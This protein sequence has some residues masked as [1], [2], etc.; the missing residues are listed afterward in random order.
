MIGQGRPHRQGEPPGG[1]LVTLLFAVLAWAAPT[2][3][4]RAAEIDDA[5]NDALPEMRLRIVF[6]GG[7]PRLWRGSISL[8]DGQFLQP[9]LLGLEP[10]E[11]GSMSA[12]VRVIHVHQP[13]SRSYEGLDVLV[14]AP[15]EA[16]LSVRLAAA[17]DPVGQ[18]DFHL[19]LADLVSGIHPADDE[20]AGRLDALGNRLV[21]SRSPGDKLRVA[22]E[23]DGL[24]F[25]PGETF[26]F[27]VVPNLPGLEADTQLRMKLRIVSRLD[28]EEHFARQQEVKVAADGC[29]DAWGP[30]EFVLPAGDDVYELIV[31][32]SRP[33]LLDPLTE[34][35]PL[36]TTK[37]LLVRRLQLVAV[38]EEAPQQTDE[39][40]EQPVDEFDP[41][42]PNWSQRVARLP[43]L[44]R[45]PRMKQGRL[46]HG[47]VEVLEHQGRRWVQLAPSAWQAHPLSIAQPGTPHVLEVEYPNDVPQTL[48]ISVLQPNAVGT[49]AP[50]GVDSAVQVQPLA[51][52]RSPGTQR[53]RLIF[54]PRTKTPLLLLT[55]H[56]PQRPAVY[57][58]VRL[59]RYDGPLAPRM[60]RPAAG[61]R[62]I[63]AWFDKPLLPEMFSA[64]EA[65]D[66]STTRSLDD[67]RTF[68]EGSTRLVRYLQHVGY[69]TAVVPA[70]C[71]GSTLYPSDILQPTPKYDTGTFLTH[72]EDPQRKDVLELL[73]RLFDRQGLTLLPSL[74]FDTPLPELE[75]L[76]RENPHGGTG[77]QLVDHRG[78]TWL[79]RFSSRGGLAPYYNPLDERVQQAMTKV[80]AELVTRYGHH[81]SFGGVVLQLSPRGH[82]MLP[83]GGWGFDDRTFARFV[84]EAKVDD[85]QLERLGGGRNRFAQ[86]ARWCAGEGRSA[87]LAWRARRMAGLYG[88]MADEVRRV[89]PEGKLILAG[90]GMLDS[91]AL[92][93]ALRPTL[94]VKGATDQIVREAILE[95]GIDPQALAQIPAVKLIAPYPA[96]A[97]PQ[98]GQGDWDEG[99]VRQLHAQLA[100]D[101]CLMF[102]E[103]LT[104]HVP[105]FDAISPFGREKTYTWLAAHVSPSGDANRRRWIGCLAHDDYPILM[106]GGWMLPRGQEDHLLGVIETLRHLPAGRLQTA[107][108]LT[109]ATQP[110]VVRTRSEQD[111]TVAC[112][113][114]NSPW[115]VTL[116]MQ[117]KASGPCIVSP[118]HARGKIPPMDGLASWTVELEPYGIVAGWFNLPGVELEVK[119][120]GLPEPLKPALEEKL[121]EV[122]SRA[123][124]L[125]VPNSSFTIPNAGFE[126]PPPGPGEIAGW[127]FSHG[128]DVEVTIASSGHGG[129]HSLKMTSRGPEAW[130]RS[131]PLPVPKTGRVAV[132][133]R[134]RVDDPQRQPRLRLAIEAR[135]ASATYYRY[136]NVGAGVSGA[137]LTQRW[138]PFVLQIDDL[139]RDGLEEFR[140]G[141][142]LMDAGEVWIDDVEIFDASFT[143]DEQLEL[144][145]RIAAAHYHL[146]NG[147]VAAAAA[148]LDGYW[149]RFLLEHVEPAA[150]ATAGP[151][152]VEPASPSSEPDPPPPRESR[153]DRFKKLLHWPF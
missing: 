129:R 71:E 133:V 85:P 7:T 120:V 63:A 59:L 21:I 17:D 41:V 76:L 15:L 13:S 38:A 28:G 90:G 122:R 4:L 29:L 98:T 113:L 49:V 118:L 126:Q 151:A 35:N 105:S 124:A 140:I 131:Q 68:Y 100:A 84:A 150:D 136:A 93:Q 101:G 106:D 32:A 50:L 145:R 22:L 112:V 111:R 99:A 148:M 46:S 2:L 91:D 20:S 10:D 94:R 96:I 69:N 12:G 149:P 43:L 95:L 86:R 152:P 55:S 34:V 27:R 103:P 40:V 70:L 130:V 80:V 33:S 109:P 19:P 16:T 81:P 97:S 89:Q 147:N 110:V 5:D 144:L 78:R 52:G 11:P 67:W 47:Q 139:P 79:K 116:R 56:D 115:P 18:R 83:G 119:E 72:G 127:L 108:P 54:W 75:R 141:F 58:R 60:A 64:T 137:A 117:V 128:D 142:D 6:G 26:R 135:R 92:R 121:E 45:I 24:V 1:A 8:S 114:N 61:R 104:R 138:A 87:W 88:Q 65:R 25:T 62:M 74:Q 53:H 31:T 143:N 146:R 123:A 102:R 82:A 44:K 153:L 14:R 77:L 51:E 48:G 23:H 134:L 37:P 36:A 57:G 107:A 66:H 132:W 9:Q 73:L 125:K 30:H 39:P 3:A 42:S